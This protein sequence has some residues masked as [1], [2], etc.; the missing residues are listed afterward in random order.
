MAHL[1]IHLADQELFL[2]QVLLREDGFQGILAAFR[3]GNTGV[4]P[5]SHRL[6][7]TPS[8]WERPETSPPWASARPFSCKAQAST[9]Q[10]SFI[11]AW[12]GLHTRKQLRSKADAAVRA[13]IYAP[14]RQT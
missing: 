3:K 10:G 2:G 4:A 14:P 5:G 8:A 12:I 6:S 13:A 11:W 7:P 9:S 1:W